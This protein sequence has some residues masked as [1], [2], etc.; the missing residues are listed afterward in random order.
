M[1]KSAQKKGGEAPLSSLSA[2]AIPDVASAEVL[3]A[4]G[5]VVA[6]VLRPVVGADAE[7]SCPA[8]AG[9]TTIWE[10][11]PAV[12]VEPVHHAPGG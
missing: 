4:A 2:S 5:G 11:A 1:A 8:T 6:S 7:I 9:R 3:Y 12:I 10:A